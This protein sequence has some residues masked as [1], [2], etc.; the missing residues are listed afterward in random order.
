MSGPIAILG[1]TS[2]FAGDYIA[3]DDRESMPALIAKAL[4]SDGPTVIGVCA[5]SNQ[6]IIPTVTSRQLPGGGLR[7]NALH[8]M[9]PALPDEVIEAELGGFIDLPALGARAG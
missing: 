6:V 4:A 7:S 2:H 8:I 5:Q 1:A 9:H 3:I